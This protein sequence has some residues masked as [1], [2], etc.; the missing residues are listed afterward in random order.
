MTDF[1]NNFTG[2]A[3]ERGALDDILGLSRRLVSLALDDLTRED[4][5]FKVED[6]EVV[7]FKFV[8]GVGGNGI[9][10]RSDQLAKV[11]D[12]HLGHMQV[13]GDGEQGAVFCGL[14]RMARR[15]RVARPLQ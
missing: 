3:F 9:A 5:V 13:Y 10:E 6:G 8:R 4:D 15:I 2:D 12:G 14:D 11:G 7:I 1:G